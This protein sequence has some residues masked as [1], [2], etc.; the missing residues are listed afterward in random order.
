MSRR[1]VGL[2]AA[3]AV[4]ALGSGCDQSP[5]SAPQA[6]G[7]SL[8]AVPSANACL[9]TG[10]P[11]LSNSAN[12]Y[13]QTTAD[14]KAAS[15]LIAVMQTG[16]SAS[17]PSGARDNGYSLLA[18]AGAASRDAS[19]AGSV[20][21]GEVMV[22]Q[23]INCMY[24]TTD[25]VNFGQDWPNSAQFDFSAALDAPN[26][27]AFFVR[28]GAGDPEGPAVGNIRSLNTTVDPAGGNVSALA[29][30]ILPPQTTPLTWSQILNGKRTLIYGEPVT[31]GF[32]WKLVPRTTSFSP[33]AVVSLCQAVHPGV[34]FSDADVIHQENV[35]TLGFEQSSACG[36]LPAT[37]ALAGWRQGSFALMSRLL[38]VADR[39]LSPEPLHATS[40]ALLATKTGGVAG[41]KGDEF[42]S[43][44]LPNVNLVFTTQPASNTKVLT[45]RVSATVTVT[46]PAGEPAGGI[47]V[48]LST[49]TNN[50]TGT[51]VFEITAA[52]VANNYKGCNP[53]DNPVGGDPWVVPPSEVTRGTVGTTGESSP[54]LAV[55]S[56]NLCFTK[57]G[58]VQLVAKSVADGYPAAGA[59][60][61][62]S[63]KS[64]V[65]P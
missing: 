9:F 19:R 5:P 47:V 62:L 23:A 57:T 10:N 35:G 53:N 61:A 11:S 24:D 41:A 48:S 46:T 33:R 34:G 36:T 60:T 64:N 50:G 32:D 56:R 54:T 37:F 39:V 63:S 17:G 40:L 65:N 14:R 49:T 16:Y 29:P 42:T 31:D 38:A 13:F 7:P 55:W 25:P 43:L 45:G 21:V 52:G 26:G 8:K 18:L 12:S 58:A 44:N 4:V 27:G 20:D 22:K 51:G 3:I 15:D 6:D 30:P 1:F 28:G 2:A 59:G